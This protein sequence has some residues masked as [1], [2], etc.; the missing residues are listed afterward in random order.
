MELQELYEYTGKHDAIVNVS[1]VSQSASEIKDFI[2][3]NDVWA[4]LMTKEDSEGKFKNLM[5][6]DTGIYIMGDSDG[7]ITKAN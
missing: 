2:E 4:I 7:L 6:L 5:D 1:G 3:R